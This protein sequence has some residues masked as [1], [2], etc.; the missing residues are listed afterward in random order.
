MPWHRVWIGPIYCTK[1]PRLHISCKGKYLVLHRVRIV[2]EFTVIINIGSSFFTKVTCHNGHICL[3]SWW[4]KSTKSGTS[5]CLY[6]KKVLI[7]AKVKRF[8]QKG[9]TQK[10]GGRHHFIKLGVRVCKLQPIHWCSSPPNP[11]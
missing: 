10:H 4:K 9:H 3:P 8:N 7:A 11:T 1:L 6:L 2:N 5:N